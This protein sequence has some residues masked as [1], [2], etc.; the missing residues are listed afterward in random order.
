M[1]VGFAAMALAATLS[2]CGGA[3]GADAPKPFVR[4]GQSLFTQAPG[5]IPGSFRIVNVTYAVDMISI[6]DPS[7]G[8]QV[9]FEQR[10]EWK[11]DWDVDSSVPTVTVTARV[12]AKGRF[13]KPL[14]SFT[15]PADEGA[16]KDGYYR[17]VE[18]GREGDD[19]VYR[20]HDL[21]TGRLVFEATTEPVIVT[22]GVPDLSGRRVISYQSRW[23]QE[24]Q[25][26]FR[27]RPNVLAVLL[28]QQ[29]GRAIDR[30]VLLA[31]PDEHPTW[32]PKLTVVDPSRPDPDH[33]EGREELTL[34]GPKGL[35]E[36][37]AWRSFDL[38]LRFETDKGRPLMVIPVKDGRFDLDAAT[39]MKGVTLRRD[40][41]PKAQ[42]QDRQR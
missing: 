6:D 14:W 25:P 35:T 22:L 36:A 21:A 24:D 10:L 19:P 12:I 34:T 7:R 30:V 11:Q 17:M 3:V 23:S 16:I 8:E 4:Q 29:D 26:P 40:V 2:H 5:E 37:Q 13:D 15:E 38:R 9:L 20:Y 32:S 27:G 42:A 41:P 18:S 28:M 1:R 33:P 31:S 39:A